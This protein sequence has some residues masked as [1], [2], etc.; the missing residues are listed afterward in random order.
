VDGYTPS[1][2]PTNRSS[3]KLNEYADAPAMTNATTFFITMPQPNENSTGK[4][5]L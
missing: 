4:S 5:R 1:N 2:P 3:A